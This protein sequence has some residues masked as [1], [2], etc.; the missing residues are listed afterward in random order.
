MFPLQRGQ[1]GRIS[2][3]IFMPPAASFFTAASM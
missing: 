3:L 1:V 2:G